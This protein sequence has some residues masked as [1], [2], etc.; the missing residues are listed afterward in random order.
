MA[1]TKILSRETSYNRWVVIVVRSER[2]EW[3]VNSVA[4]LK[5]SILPKQW[6]K[7]VYTGHHKFSGSLATI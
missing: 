5:L 7:R 4:I 2:V 1:V 6:G 3:S